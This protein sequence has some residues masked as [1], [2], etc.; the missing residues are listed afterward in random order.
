VI[1]RVAVAVLS[2]MVGAC[3]PAVGPDVTL[4]VRDEPI[5]WTAV[6]TDR[7]YDVS[8]CLMTRSS[9]D[10]HNLWIPPP[11]IDRGAGVARVTVSR[12]RPY[13]PREAEML[14]AYSLRELG[15]NRL[16]VQW[17]QRGEPF[18]GKTF[19]TWARQNAD[20]CGKR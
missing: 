3:A 18:T 7:L 17:R 1:R 6:Y 12:H 15:D 14:G 9:M 10:S 16:E 2:L 5:R 19:A 11:E 4:D 8:Y 13:T 20:A